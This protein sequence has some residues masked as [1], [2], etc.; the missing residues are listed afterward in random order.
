MGLLICVCP[1][2]P[3]PC[4]PPTCPLPSLF[5]CISSLYLYAYMSP[6]SSLYV[7]AM[8]QT[9]PSSSTYSDIPIPLPAS[10]ACLLYSFHP[11]CASCLPSSSSSLLCIPVAIQLT[12]FL[13]GFVPDRDIFFVCPEGLEARPLLFL[14]GFSLPLCCICLVWW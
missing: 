14:P 9:L 4:L 12:S 3:V 6:S 13:T 10:S 2:P 11:C 8:C 7:C 1:M 5:P